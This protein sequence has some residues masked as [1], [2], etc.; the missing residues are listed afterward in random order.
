MANFIARITQGNYPVAE[1]EGSSKRIAL[2]RAGARLDR[3]RGFSNP[4]PD[5]NQWDHLTITVFK[6]LRRAP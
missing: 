4:I 1:G 2:Q 5:G 6:D 3:A